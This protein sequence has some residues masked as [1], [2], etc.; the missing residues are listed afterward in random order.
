MIYK[1][2]KKLCQIFSYP[3]FWREFHHPESATA[4]KVNQTIDDENEISSPPI[5]QIEWVECDD[6]YKPLAKPIQQFLTE[7]RI[8]AGKLS[9]VYILETAH[10]DLVEHL[11]KDTRVEH[12]GILFGN[13]YTDDEYGVYVEITA[14]VAAPATMGTGA[15]LEFTAESWLGIMDYAKAA[16]PSANIVGWYHSHPNIGVFM[17]GTDMRTQRAFFY[18]PWCLSIV[19]DP[20]RNEIG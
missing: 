10:T 13:A 12:G 11:R 8:D 9:Q 3:I 4:I 19:C 15:Y 20:V 18:H 5:A 2:T 17:S 16:H 14:A 6:V 7:R 1:I